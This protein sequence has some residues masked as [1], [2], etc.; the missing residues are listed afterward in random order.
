MTEQGPRGPVLCGLGHRQWERLRLPSR[1]RG[2]RFLLCWAVVMPLGVE[3]GESLHNCVS[4]PG[5]EGTW[6]RPVGEM[7]EQRTGE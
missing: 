6:T 4:E 3:G 7:K 5:M 2:G 1:G